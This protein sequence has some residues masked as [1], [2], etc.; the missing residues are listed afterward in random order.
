MPYNESSLVKLGALK[1]LAERTKSELDAVSL[2]A[3]SAIK[4]VSTAGN[5]VSFFTSADGTGTAAFTVDFPN[6]MVLDA[7]RT[8]FVP[9]F[10]FNPTTY[11]GAT[12]P[13]LEGKPVLVLAVKTTTAA[14]AE[15]LNFS[16]LNLE[17]LIDVYTIK[18]GDSAKVLSISGNEIEFHVSAIANNAITVQAD[19]LHV[20]ISDKTDKVANATAG[21]LAGLDANGN[22]TDSGSGIATAAEVTEMLNGVF[23]TPSGN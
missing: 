16:F 15:T 7:A 9:N 8:T 5:T 17:T 2:V 19:G 18:T 10:A 3:A 22:L 4:Y 23:G 11:P 21:N 14:G 6:E 13:S 20:N 12:N 1:S